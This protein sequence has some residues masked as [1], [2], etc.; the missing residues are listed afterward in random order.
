MEPDGTLVRRGKIKINDAEVSIEWR[1]KGSAD[2]RKMSDGQNRQ[3]EVT[4]PVVKPAG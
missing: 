3:F 4:V 1:L 2:H